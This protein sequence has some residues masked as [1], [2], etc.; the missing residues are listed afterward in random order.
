MRLRVLASMIALMALGGCVTA[1]AQEGSEGAE[2]FV[3]VVYG[4]YQDDHPWPIDETQLDA[5]WSP[6]M[7]ALI[8]RDRELAGDELPYLDAD[9]ICSCQDF[10]NLT[11]QHVQIYQDRTGRYGSRMARVE[12]TNAG[13][14]VTVVLS[15]A[16]NPNQGWRIDDVV[17]QDGYPSLAEALLASN[18]GIESGGRAGGRD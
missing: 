6:R 18:A 1:S 8:R 5:V 10:E 7:A 14:Q 12:F 15:L 9:P 13:E 11:V 4:F 2:R 16:G 3:R 17:N